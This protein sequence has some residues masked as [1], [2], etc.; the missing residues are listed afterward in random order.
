MRWL[1][2]HTVQ[3]KIWT[4][5]NTSFTD[6]IT[7]IYAHIKSQIPQIPGPLL[8][9]S[10]H[11]P[12]LKQAEE[13]LRRWKG[14][15]CLVKNYLIFPLKST[16]ELSNFRPNINGPYFFVWALFLRIRHSVHRNTTNLQLRRGYLVGTEIHDDCQ[17]VLHYM[18]RNCK[19]VLLH[20]LEHCC[21]DKTSLKANHRPTN[22]T[23]V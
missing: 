18:C 14:P 8:T 22:V 17:N 7:I 6:K 11:Y 3:N 21:G 9:S 15:I 13:V 1:V 10:L 5:A 4:W 2:S 12:N 23:A 16:R 20:R 19:H